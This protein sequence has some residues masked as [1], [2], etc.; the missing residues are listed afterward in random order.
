MT[1]KLNRVT[2]KV[3][4]QDLDLKLIMD[5][6]HEW[7]ISMRTLMNVYKEDFYSLKNFYENNRDDFEEDE[8]YIRIEDDSI[9][10]IRTLWTK[11]GAIQFA[12]LL[13]SDRAEEFK[14]WAENLKID[15]DDISEENNL[16]EIQ[17][18]NQDDATSIKNQL[19]TIMVDNADNQ[20]KDGFQDE[21]VKFTNKETGA[22][23]RTIID[24]NGNPLFCLKDLCDALELTAS[25]VRERLSPDVVSNDVRYESGQGRNM[26]FVNEDGM[27]DVILDSRKP[28]AKRFRK[29]ITSEVL[30]SIRKTGSYS[31]KQHLQLPSFLPKDEIGWI[32]YALT[33]KKEEKRLL[34]ENN[35]LN[36]IIDEQKET[37]EEL[38]PAAEKYKKYIDSDG[39]MLIRTIATAMELKYFNEEQNKYINLGQ[40]RLFKFLKDADELCNDNTPRNKPNY[41]KYYKIKKQRIEKTG[42]SITTTYITP[43]GA[44]HI[45]S[46]L[47]KRKDLITLK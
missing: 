23:V 29:W 22:S 8:H 24:E 20:V 30:P 31:S 41:E 46:L 11:K 42:K 32:E 39:L 12:D 13:G 2:K 26:T 27:Y 40:N 3:K 37:I 15:E 25:H 33:S 16:L 17:D 6:N 44:D 45:E 38:T 4:F 14:T 10:K 18:D 19:A 36:I 9:N 7:L 28:E 21:L 5:K 34:A 43:Q 47:H 1:I 35:Q